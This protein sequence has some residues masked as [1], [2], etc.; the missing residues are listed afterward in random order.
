MCY[1]HGIGM[2]QGIVLY[3]HVWLSIA[4]A[5]RTS[6]HSICTNP[7][8][9]MILVSG[10]ISALRC[11]NVHRCTLGVYAVVCTFMLFI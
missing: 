5:V 6:Y 3:E 11:S 4:I 9:L 1:E 7:E 10:T 8:V 2:L